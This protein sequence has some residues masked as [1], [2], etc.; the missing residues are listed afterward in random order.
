[1]GRLLAF[2]CVLSACSFRHGAVD[3][4]SDG[5]GAIDA[6]ADG[7]H[8]ID[9]RMVDALSQVTID[10][11][12]W[13]CGTMPAAPGSTITMSG[14]NGATTIT[15]TAIDFASSG[16]VFIATA[17]SSISYTIHYDITDTACPGN[18]VDQIEIGYVP[19][20]RVACPFDAQVSKANGASGT[21]TATMTAP[22]QTGS[23]D[24]RTNIGQNYS[25]TYNGA[26]GWWGGTTPSA[27]WTIAKLCVH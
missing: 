8:V 5:A 25:C 22:T 26:T 2:A 12:T 1:M 9:A 21:I 7:A 20:G 23:Y 13:P 24:I 14:N 16:Q 11:S 6:P 10:A 27:A 17:G 4:A 19:G 3:E 15:L 18:C